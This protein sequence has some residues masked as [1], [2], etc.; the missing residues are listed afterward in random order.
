M[1]PTTLE[2][3]DAELSYFAGFLDPAQADRLLACLLHEIDWQSGRVRLFG[4]EYPIPRLQAFQGDTGVHY[5][6]SGQRLAAT[7]WHPAL[8]ALKQQLEQ[9]C[10]QPFNALLL[11]LYRDGEDAMGWHAD[12]EPEL[13]HCPL[14]ASVSL[15]A[16]RR[17]RLRHN[18]SRISHALELEH[19][20]LLLMG[21]PTQHH[22]QHCLPRTR[23]CQQPRINLTF[24]L[25]H[26]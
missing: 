1:K 20:S 12:N 16:R 23:R 14:I 26:V 21:G 11:N 2:L 9:L 5:R 22:W 18:R 19:G 7:P 8:L 3:P 6:Y 10:Q 17:F 13:G 24:R 25:I 4:R 15:G